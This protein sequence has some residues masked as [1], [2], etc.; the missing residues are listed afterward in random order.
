MSKSK[1]PKDEERLV[2]LMN[3]NVSRGKAAAAAVH[4][5]LLHYGIEH[6]AVICLGSKGPEIEEDCTTVVRD[7]GRTE[8]DPGTITAGVRDHVGKPFSKLGKKAQERMARFR[9][10]Q[11]KKD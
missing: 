1:S 4:A 8:V 7:A 11:F 2:I 6:G 3:S 10:R 5:A 9:T